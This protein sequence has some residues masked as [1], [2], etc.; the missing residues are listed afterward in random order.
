MFELSNTH[1]FIIFTVTTIELNMYIITFY[2]IRCFY[3]QHSNLSELWF[4]STRRIKILM[5]KSNI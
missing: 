4:Q 2:T 5:R 1:Q 3:N